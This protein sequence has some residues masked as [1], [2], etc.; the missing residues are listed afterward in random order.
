VAEWLGT[1]LQNLSRRFE[2]ARDLTERSEGDEQGGA[3]NAA[4]TKFRS[5]AKAT[6][7]EYNSDEGYERSSTRRSKERRSD[8]V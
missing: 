8:E 4:P 6:E 7:D 2:P 5:E 3:R 1:G